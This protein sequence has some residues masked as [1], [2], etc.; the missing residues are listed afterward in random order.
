MTIKF[1]VEIN[2]IHCDMDGVL[3]DFDRF[4]FE[5]MGRTFEHSSGPGADDEM[6]NFLRGVDRLYYKLEPTPYATLLWE[7]ICKCSNYQQ[8]LTAI[9][10][11]ASVPTA[12]ADKI[13]WMAERIDPKAVVKIGP[14]SRDKWKHAKPGDILIDDRADNIAE[15]IE[16]GQG[17]GIFHDLNNVDATLLALNEIITAGKM[18]SGE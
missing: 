12:E 10:R 15:W 14:Y 16:K 5:N 7:T 6:W 8:V 17:I 3:A 9:P 13:Q 11:R 4:V 18:L 1:D 2:T